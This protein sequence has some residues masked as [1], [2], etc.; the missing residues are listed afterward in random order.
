[1]IY[2]VEISSVWAW[3][4]L[5]PAALMVLSCIYIAPWRSLFQLSAR[6]HVF[7]LSLVF[8]SLFWTL[9]VRVHDVFL[10]H[11][12]LVTSLVFVFGL[13]ISL[14]I[15]ALSLLIALIVLKVALINWGASFVC[16]VL[17]PA[18]VSAAIL[19]L[20]TTLRVQNVF[21]YTL[22]GAFFGGIVAMLSVALIACVLTWLA[23]P[24]LYPTFTENGYAFFLLA[25]PEGFCNG[26]IV[27][28]MAILAPKLVKTFDDDFYFKRE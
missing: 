11:P 10:F 17:A 1:M 13:R 22:G 5:A 24:S 9:G 6:Q 4:L 25:F 3:W 21:L 19:R 18:V 2:L 14:V 7:Y 12:L 28:T 15:G 16:S 27:S 26:A 23:S 20:I 8:F